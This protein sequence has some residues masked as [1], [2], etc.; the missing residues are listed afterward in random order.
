LVFGSFKYNFLF[1]RLSVCEYAPNNF[2]FAVGNFTEQFDL[3]ITEGQSTG[4]S[5]NATFEGIDTNLLAHIIWNNTIYS[6]SKSIIG[7][8]LVQFSSTFVVPEG[9]GTNIGNNITHNW[10]YWLPDGS[11]NATTDPQNQTVFSLEADNCDVLTEVLINYTMYDEDTLELI[12]SNQNPS[13]EVDLEIVSDLDPNIVFE[14]SDTYNSSSALV[15]VSSITS[16]FTVNAVAQYTALDYVVEFLNMQNV[17]LSTSNFPKNISL[18]PLL[19]T[20]S[21]EFLINFKDSNFAPVER[22]LITVTRKYIGEGLFRTVEA[23]LTNVDGQAIVHLVLGDVIYT[24]QVSKDGV[25][26]GNFPNIVPFC[27]NVA[28]GD[29][30]I[31]LNALSSGTS[32]SNFVTVL[33]SAFNFVFD[34]VARTI[35]A[36]FSTLNGDVS[37]Y[38]LTATVF[39]N[40]GNNTFCSKTQT[41][42]SGSII[43]NIPISIG[44]TTILAELYKDGVFL[45][46]QTFNLQDSSDADF[47]TS[48]LI[49]MLI[50]YIT[51]PLMMI[52]SGIGIVIASI[53]GMVFAGILNLY[54]GGSILGVSSTIIWF[55][56]AGGILIWK[57][58]QKKTG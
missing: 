37:E 20:R 25:L 33:G 3:T 58:N 42:S 21:Q 5:L 10:R 4:L 16:G 39:D 1:C 56:I 6:A 12:P 17:S 51:I 41:T 15:C 40:R 19:S 23:P 7:S 30:T 35:T 9:S 44:N 31:N 46:Y 57:I 27:V 36:V 2:T 49:M 52:S 29:C 34:K 18:Y 22:A 54:T 38:N 43:C 50:L 11:V 28:T 47:G 14:F 13:I 32:P 45:G 26:L 48:G 53:L 8:D 55:I 24:I